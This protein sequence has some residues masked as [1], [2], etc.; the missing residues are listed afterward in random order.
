MLDG[1]NFVSYLVMA[2]IFIAVVLVVLALAP[3]FNRTIDMGARLSTAALVPA[4]ATGAGGSL[5]GDPIQSVWARLITEIERRGLSLTDT[6]GDVLAE[7]LMLAGY[8]Q[9][10]AV[11]AYVLARTVLTVLLPILA[12]GVMALTNEWPAPTK[13]YMII[14]GAA[15]AGLYLPNFV[16]SN[17]AGERRKEIINGFPDTL[18]LMLVCIEAGLGVDATFNRVGSEIT[19]SHPLLASL[20]ASVA[21]ELRAGRSREQA[22]KT[23]AR[24]SGVPEIAAFSTLIIQSDKLGASISQAL[25]V[26]ASEMREGRRMRA[27][28][29]AARIPVLL[30]LPLVCFLLPCMVAVLMLPAGISMT[31]SMEKTEANRAR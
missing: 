26:Y 5:R 29:K 15:F 23:L 20:F 19:K 30:S 7:R 14:L 13:L 12:V 21:L 28:E 3:L 18:D 9:P 8:E 22:L 1:A 11:R 17:R 6:K 4:A 2:M 25:R 16:I 27:E 31:R 10:F 24:K